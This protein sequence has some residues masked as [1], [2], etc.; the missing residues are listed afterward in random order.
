[1]QYF[2][3]KVI[4]LKFET[5]DTLTV[6]FKQPA[7]KRISYLAG[8]YLTLIFRINNRKYIRPYSFSSAPG[9][10]Q[11]L[12]IT[13]KRMNG[14]IVSNHIIDRLKIGDLVE[15]MSPMGDFTLEKVT[16]N[17]DIFLWGAGSGITPLMSIIKY[18]LNNNIGKNIKL[19]YGNRN[20]EDIIFNDQIS[21]LKKQYPYKLSVC[22]FFTR[23]TLT[24]ENPYIMEGRIDPHKILNL[25]KN[26]TDINNS[27][28]FI[29]GPEGLKQSVKSVLFSKGLNDN[30][31]FS[32]D[33]IITRDPK[34]F[35]NIS[36]TNV[37]ITNNSVSSVVEVARGK[38]ILEAGLDGLIDLPYSCQTGNCLVCK[39]KLIKGDIKMIGLKKIPTELKENECLL[40]CSYPLNGDVE[41]IVE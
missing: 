26:E 17:S 20:L 3:L 22:H 1:M 11:S 32:E 14:G 40:C 13:V 38:N 30:Q 16:D 21:E 6:S 12:D 15:V 7:L 8:Q 28:H 10:D 19:I 36:T 39:A 33:F 5:V 31:V 23:I 2:T 41:L 9:V 29:C 27:F 4:K 18:A 34:E 35:E 25:F 24:P 37:S